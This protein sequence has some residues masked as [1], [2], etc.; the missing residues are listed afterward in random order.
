MSVTESPAEFVW[1][2]N[3]LPLCA[4]VDGAHRAATVSAP[5]PSRITRE[6]EIRS[7]VRVIAAKPPRIGD[8]L[9][10]MST[11]LFPDVA[12]EHLPA[13][14]GAVDIAVGID[15]DTLGARMVGDLPLRFFDE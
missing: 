8:S 4:E 12:L 11:F 1:T 3:A 6:R 15:A 10:R 9:H 2:M 7:T 13:D 14:H 5:I